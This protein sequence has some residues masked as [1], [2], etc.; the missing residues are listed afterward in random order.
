METHNVFGYTRR[1]GAE[2]KEGQ[3]QKRLLPNVAFLRLRIAPYPSMARTAFST[4]T[5]AVVRRSK[6]W[7]M[8]SAWARV[9]SSN[10]I[11]LGS[12]VLGRDC[13][14]FF[15]S[16][17]ELRQ[18]KQNKGVLRKTASTLKNEKN[19]NKKEKARVKEV[20]R[21]LSAP[22]L[23]KHRRHEASGQLAPQLLQPRFLSAA[24][25]KKG[26]KIYLLRLK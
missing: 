22:L 3:I 14:R 19:K 20:Q 5:A 21:N 15:T 4:P 7:P 11:S 18:E 24:K 16:L 1:P 6:P 25:I 8:W 10:S 9:R 17:V 13:R 26:C 12:L 23:P 2:S